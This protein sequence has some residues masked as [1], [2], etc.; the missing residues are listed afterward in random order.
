MVHTRTKS[1]RGESYVFQKKR[2]RHWGWMLIKKE[3]IAT[4][5]KYILWPTGVVIKKDL[6]RQIGNFYLERVSFMKRQ[7]G[8]EQGRGLDR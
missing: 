7:S 8:S 2:K 1:K 4:G 3:H 6:W 5:E